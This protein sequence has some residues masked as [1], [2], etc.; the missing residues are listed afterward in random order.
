M[1]STCLFVSLL[2]LND[3]KRR[4]VSLR[5]LS[6]LFNFYVCCFVTVEVVFMPSHGQTGKWRRNVLYLSVR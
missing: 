1:F 4:V 5:Q 3:T 2:I 6:F